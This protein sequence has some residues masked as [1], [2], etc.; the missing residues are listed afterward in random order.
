[1]TLKQ[2]Y[3]EKLG[4]ISFCSTNLLEIKAAPFYNSGA[5][6]TCQS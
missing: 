3:S 2:R 1:M 4:R 6:V 5:A